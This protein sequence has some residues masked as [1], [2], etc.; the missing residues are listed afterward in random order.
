MKKK[1][2][3]T[4][5]IVMVIIMFGKFIGFIR[6]SILASKFGASYEMDIYSYSITIL[7]FLAT[8]GY[9][10][11]TT[12]IPIFSKNR[13]KDMDEQEKLANNLITIMFLLG[14]TINII[15]ILFSKYIVKIF[16]P[17]FNNDNLQIAKN[18][19][20]IMN[21]SLVSI[22]IQSV[23]S[24]ILQAYDKFYTSAAMA[25]IGNI[26]SIIYLLFFIDD[27]GIYGFGVATLIGYIF[28][29][30][31]NIPSYR[32]LGFRY[33]F[34]LDLNN[35][36]TIDIFKITIP[37]LVSTCIIQ[38]S[39]IITTFYGSLIGEGAISTFNYS[40][41]LINLTVEIFAIGMS[42]VIY[43]LLSK[44]D[45]EKESDK[46]NEIL[47]RGIL[48]MCI[49]VIP[50][51]ILIIVL[52]KDIIIFLYERNEFTRENT[53]VTSKILLILSPVIICSSI[54]DLLNKASY[55]LG[56]ANISMKISIWMIILSIIG[57]FLLYKRIGIY[58]LGIVVTLV[59][60]F[61][62]IYTFIFLTKKFKFIRM[63]IRK[64]VIKIFIASAIMGL[65][66]WN[67]KYFTTE[68]IS[69]LFELVIYSMLGVIIYVV[70]IA[71][72]F[73][74]NI[75]DYKKKGSFD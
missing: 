47:K 36:Q 69:K 25:S 57:N 10:I 2:I 1:V 38:F 23:L 17:G 70:L 34:R 29:M 33:K 30:F 8:I 3:S 20:I 44:V 63:H 46:F 74:K 37:V 56:E 32:K 5:I 22:F 72:L 50:I 73:R 9:S 54:R 48:M 16:A 49:V 19:I 11:T 59:N 52:N 13:M 75:N 62:T 42:M 55:S 7:L 12:T 61:G 35:K 26:I 64:D 67:M 60:I 40:N 15:T 4:Q 24:G 58:G 21:F 51:C 66:V 53:I 14:L 6:E 27:F 71:I 31:I 41:R 43:P 65:V 39:S 18:L 28:Q 68:I 45:L